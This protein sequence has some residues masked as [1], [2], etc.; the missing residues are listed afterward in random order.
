MTNSLLNLVY[1]LVLKALI[2]LNVNMGMMIKNV[3][4]VELNKNTMYAFLNTQTLLVISYYTN[5][6]FTIKVNKNSLMKLRDLLLHSNFLTMTFNRNS[7]K[8]TARERKYL[9]S[10]K[11][12][13]YYC[14]H[15]ERV[16]KHFEI[17]HVGKYHNLYNRCI[18]DS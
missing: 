18:I 17:R 2:K 15:T 7:M 6:S 1:N 14:K 16:C 11:H 10:L 4:R 8:H 13:G 12:G 5:V 9:Q 3:K